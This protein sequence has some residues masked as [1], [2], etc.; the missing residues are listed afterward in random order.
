[1]CILAGPAAFSNCFFCC[2]WSF[3]SFFG[4]DKPYEPLKIFP[5]HVRLSRRPSNMESNIVAS[6]VAA[7][8][9]TANLAHHIDGITKVILQN[10]EY[11]T[12]LNVVLCLQGW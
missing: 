3:N 12:P 9:L 5:F 8:L 2:S 6:S 11:H 4:R 10:D 1:M 7:A